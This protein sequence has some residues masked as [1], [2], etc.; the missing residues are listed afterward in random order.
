MDTFRGIRL[1]PLT[2]NPTPIKVTSFSKDIFKNEIQIPDYIKEEE[3]IL[4]FNDQLEV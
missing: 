1:K 2:E 4:K 3:E